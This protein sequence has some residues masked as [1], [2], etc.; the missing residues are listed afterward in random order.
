MQN[1]QQLIG[2]YLFQ[3]II[4]RVA[5]TPATNGCSSIDTMHELQVSNIRA[6]FT[7]QPFTQQ[8][9]TQQPFTQQ[10]FTQQP[11]TAA[12]LYAAAVHRS[13]RIPA[14]PW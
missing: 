3:V 13:S 1:A 11:F 2:S 10:P 14:I 7:Q 8:P 6:P 12:A 4:S 9:F 5:L